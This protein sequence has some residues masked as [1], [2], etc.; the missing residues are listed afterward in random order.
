MAGEGRRSRRLAHFAG[1]VGEVIK[2]DRQVEVRFSSGE[3]AKFNRPNVAR[4]APT[5]S[6]DPSE[7]KEEGMQRGVHAAA[8][9]ASL[10]DEQFLAKHHLPP[11]PPR[12]PAPADEPTLSF[13]DS[14]MTAE[15]LGLP[16]LPP[17]SADAIGIM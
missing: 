13:M 14:F 12:S 6:D 8:A 4:V 1:M 10:P 16:P 3:T 5:S 17:P 11:P 2:V 15:E 7:Y 9:A